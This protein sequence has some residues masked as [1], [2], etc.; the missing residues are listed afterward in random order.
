MSTKKATRHKSKQTHE[1][2]EAKMTPAERFKSQ[3]GRSNVPYGTFTWEEVSI[4]A[5]RANTLDLM[6]IGALPKSLFTASESGAL[7]G[8]KNVSIKDLGMTAEDMIHML[9]SGSALLC[10]T[11]I[12]PEFSDGPDDKR[13]GALDVNDAG[14]ARE[15]IDAYAEWQLAGAFGVPVEAV[16][17]GEADPEDIARFLEPK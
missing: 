15:M 16:G 13:P 2:A 5:R 7:D 3:M 8:K 4:K 6:K 12:E 1:A 9:S 10:A 17:G 14:V 11:A